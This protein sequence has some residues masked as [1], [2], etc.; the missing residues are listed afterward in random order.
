MKNLK[1]KSLLVLLLTILMLFYI[2]R[3]D[4]FDV[5]NIIKTANLLW[6]IMA[7]AINYFGILIQ[8]IP[9][10]LIINQYNKAYSLRD[11]FKLGIIAEFVNGIT[12]L[13]SGG[14][15]FQ[16]YEL[17]TNKIKLTDATSIVV[18]N[19]LIYEIALISL[20]IICYIIN[21]VF[22]IVNFTPVLMVMFWVGLIFN[23]IIFLFTYIIGSSKIISKGTSSIVASILA[24]LKII[25]DTKKVTSNLENTW[26]KIYNSFKCLKNNKTIII[27]CFILQF[28]GICITFT[29]VYFIFN[30]LNL[31]NNINLLECIVTSTFAFISGSFIPI[32]GG[33][34]S[35]E[36]VFFQF[37]GYFIVGA[38]LKSI[39]LI[40]RFVTFIFPVLFGG[41]LF[42]LQKNT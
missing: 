14:Q 36:Y 41:I 30:A 19:Y 24:K 16:I 7:I 18:G 25:K 4:F 2:L 42:N 29:S 34:G 40:W 22:N 10:K 35:V 20:S 5:L 9:L 27:K 12:P 11:I 8:T 17:H 37:F 33:T 23:S 31:S 3:N 1:G 32:P 13:A 15:P 26:D 6:I 38:S 28:T 39:L 21:L